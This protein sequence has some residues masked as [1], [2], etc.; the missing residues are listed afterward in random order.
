MINIYPRVLEAEARMR[1]RVL[2]LMS[3]GVPSTGKDHSCTLKLRLPHFQIHA[4]HYMTQ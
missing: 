1:K 3:L 2:R 4:G